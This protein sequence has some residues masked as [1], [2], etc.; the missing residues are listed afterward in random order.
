MATLTNNSLDNCEYI[1]DFLGG[2]IP[3]TTT[4]YMCVFNQTTPSVSWT[5][6]TNSAYNDIALRVVTGGS[7][8]QISGS[9][10]FSSVLTTKSIGLSINPASAGVGFQ[11]ASGN[12]SVGQAHGYSPG[13]GLNLQGELANLPPHVHSFNRNRAQPVLDA[14]VARTNATLTGPFNSGS[15]GSNVQHI[16]TG[17]WGLHAHGVTNSAT[18]GHQITGSHSHTVSG[19]LTQENFA[20]LYRDVVIAEKNKKP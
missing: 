7:G 16:H 9:T 10:V 15:S 19:P 6:V 4:G 12:V 5:K 11:Q 18:H 17:N 3:G 14:N 8:N 1:E 20:V 2:Y 13:Q